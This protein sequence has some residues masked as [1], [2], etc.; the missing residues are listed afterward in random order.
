MHVVS[1]VYD[2]AT[3]RPHVVE[4]LSELDERDSNP[5]IIDVEAADSREDGRRQA[6]LEIKNAVRI[7]TTPEELFD[8]DGRPDFS[9]GA[10][11]TEADTGRRTLHVG[12]DGLD[13]LRSDE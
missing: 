9:I 1:F 6:M 8:D 13:A 4:I 3:R 7:G 10:L 11:I 2:S 12:Q 5:E